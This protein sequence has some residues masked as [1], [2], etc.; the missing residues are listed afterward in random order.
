MLENIKHIIYNRI[1]RIETINR[2]Y[3]RSYMMERIK[4][5]RI[6]KKDLV[7]DLRIF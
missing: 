2:E 6:I 1:Y 3:N 5:D 7:L 4:E